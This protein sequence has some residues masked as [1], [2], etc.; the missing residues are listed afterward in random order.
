MEDAAVAAAECKQAPPVNEGSV[1]A[2]IA[3]PA[4]GEGDRT[5]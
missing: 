3:D 2:E 4:P 5:E 1:D